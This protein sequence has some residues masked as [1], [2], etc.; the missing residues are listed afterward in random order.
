MKQAKG[1]RTVK[2][3]Q[4][5]DEVISQLQEQISVGVYK[6]GAKI[7]TEPELM[8]QLGVSRTTVREAVRVLA[9]AGLLE[10][11]QG[12]GTYVRASSTEVEPLEQRLRRASVLEIF[13]VRQL[14]EIEI[15]KIA[16]LRRTDQDLL[17]M[18]AGLEKKEQARREHNLES[19]IEGDI[20]F[21]NAIAV[22]SKNTVLIDLYAA[23]SHTLHVGLKD[24]FNNIMPTNE[25]ILYNHRQ[26]WQAIKA[27]N[28]EDAQKWTLAS[29]NDTMH[30]LS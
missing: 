12:D 1:L 21:H 19:Y 2:R 18:N 16:A 7:P 24:L 5:V 22:A 9:S 8:E 14:L 27:Q 29:L 30:R 6:I 25:R 10:V 3:R 11:R 26:L 20:A 23:F 15:A 13:E 4:L 17:A 28:P